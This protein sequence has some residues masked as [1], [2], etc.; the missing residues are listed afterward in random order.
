MMKAVARMMMTLGLVLLL[1][2][3]LV[4]LAALT[5]ANL[6]GDDLA[7]VA[8]ALVIMVGGLYVRYGR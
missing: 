3:L 2:A 6:V 1:L 4:R 7:I 8:S 5:P